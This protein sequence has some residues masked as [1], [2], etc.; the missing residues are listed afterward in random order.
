MHID[1][2]NRTFTV[3][4]PQKLTLDSVVKINRIIWRLELDRRS[5]LLVTEAVDIDG[6]HSRNGPVPTW[7]DTYNLCIL[8][9]RTSRVA[10]I[11]LLIL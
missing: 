2:R 10:L 9:A 4:G 11:K 7:I 6:L 3:L 8:P 1:L 5:R